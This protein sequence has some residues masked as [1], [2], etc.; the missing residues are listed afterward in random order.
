MRKSLGHE[1]YGKRG[2][3][4]RDR[5]VPAFECLCAADLV[6][7]TFRELSDVEGLR[8]KCR[9]LCEVVAD[10]LLEHRL[11]GKCINVKLK[12]VDFDVRT[13]AITLRRPTNAAG[14]IFTAAWQVS[15]NRSIA[16]Q[17]SSPCSRSEKRRDAGV[18]RSLPRNCRCAC[19]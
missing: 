19:A 1:R 18:P 12:T 15:A 6:H 4:S 10:D 5:G 11:L 7:R 2:K 3:R 13:R 17:I 8:A 9:E 16:A 14:D